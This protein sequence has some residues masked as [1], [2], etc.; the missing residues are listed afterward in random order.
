MRL[1]DYLIG[2]A[3]LL[4]LPFIAWWGVNQSPQSASMLEARL[5][6]NAQRSLQAAG[7]DWAGVEMDGQTA[8]LTGAAPSEDSVAEAAAIVLRSSGTGGV[9]L[10]GVSQVQARVTP[11][12]P[13]RPYVWIVE[14]KADGTMA[15]SGHV[16]SNAVREAL[17]QEADIAFN[18]PVADWMV[19]TSGAADGNWQGIA[20]FAIL[21]V[22][23]L[24]TGQAKLADHVLTVRGNTRDDALRTRLTAAISGVAAPF[25]GAALIRGEPLWSAHLE[26]GALVLAGQAP[27]EADRRAI[28]TA[29]GKA[30]DGEVRDEMVIAATSAEG[31]VEGTK[32]GLPHFARFESGRMT[33]DPVVN[34]FTF[35]G[36]ARASTLQFL[37]EDMTRTAGRWRFV[38]VAE[39]GRLAEDTRGA[40]AASCA[41]ILNGLLAKAAASFESGR[42]VFSREAAPALDELAVMARRCDAAYALELSI[43]GDALAEARAATIADFLERTGTQRPRL[44]AIGY[45]P[46]ASVEG[47]DTEPDRAAGSQIEFTVRERSGQ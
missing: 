31:W 22:A 32:A 6:A 10:G 24:E 44:A 17:K 39:P 25:R 15:L 2:F 14:K 45:G 33:F 36:V 37:N 43:D 42:A 40:D 38:S 12:P 19:V 1:L 41:D 26:E 16:P 23:Q 3:A 21:Q 11:A 9:L 18:G 5:Q 46:V 47:M 34:G 28:L 30:F 20:R 13:V 35:D 27:S 4:A 8:I 7:I 29:A